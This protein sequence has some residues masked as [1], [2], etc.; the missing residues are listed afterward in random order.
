MRECIEETG[1]QVEIMEQICWAEMYCE[2]PTIGYFHPIQ[3]YYSGELLQR[4]Q[5]PTEADRVFRWIGKA[6]FL[7]KS[8][9]RFSHG[10]DVI[11]G[12][13]AI[14]VDVCENAFLYFR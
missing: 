7:K 12:S 11:Q 4:M 14:I 1:Y 6:Q 9:I 3:F 8:A 5:K 13:G 2:H 10:S